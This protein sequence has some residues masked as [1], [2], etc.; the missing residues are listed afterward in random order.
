[1]AIFLCM[2]AGGM[3]FVSSVITPKLSHSTTN[4]L[5][6]ITVIVVAGISQGLLLPVLSIFWSKKEF[7]LV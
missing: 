1:M 2:L 6:L 4:Y 5:V 7:H 3:I